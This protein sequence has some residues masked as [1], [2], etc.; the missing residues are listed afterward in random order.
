MTNGSGNVWVQIRNQQRTYQLAK[1]I[2][3][4]IV[5]GIPTMYGAMGV[6]EPEIGEPLS[7]IKIGEVD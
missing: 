5:K 3:F 6:G 2:C 7:K 1:Y 4:K